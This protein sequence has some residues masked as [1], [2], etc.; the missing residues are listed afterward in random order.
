MEELGHNPYG[1]ISHTLPDED[2]NGHVEEQSELEEGFYEVEEV[3]NCRLNKNMTFDYRFRFKGYGSEDDMWLPALDLCHKLTLRFRQKQKHKTYESSVLV[4]ASNDKSS[5]KKSRLSKRMKA[6]NSGT[7]TKEK[8]AHHT[9]DDQKSTTL[10]NSHSSDCKRQKAP[11]KKKMRS[12][13][14]KGKHFCQGLQASK[15]V[16][17]SATETMAKAN[18]NVNTL[19]SRLAKS[20]H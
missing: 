11:E 8:V 10:V 12:K 19:S 20:G 15:S 2:N 6:D 9:H 13:M 14:A 16:K 1:K 17:I 3:L 5:G 18:E 7:E 4:N